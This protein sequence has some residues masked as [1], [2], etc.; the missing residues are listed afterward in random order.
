MKCFS[1]ISANLYE[2]SSYY[3]F[4]LDHSEEAPLFFSKL[5]I[6]NIFI[7]LKKVRAGRN[8][9]RLEY[10]Y[11]ENPM[12]R[13]AWQATARGV[14]KESD[15]TERECSH[16]FTSSVFMTFKKLQ[17]YAHGKKDPERH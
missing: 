4:L 5:F 15:R 12:D 13:G 1:R 6:S 9:N 8:D 14:S 10:F 16:S 3:H 11:L 7:N 17:K 2:G